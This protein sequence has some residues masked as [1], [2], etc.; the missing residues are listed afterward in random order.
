MKLSPANP[1]FLNMRDAILAALDNKF[2]AQQLT[3]DEHARVQEGIWVAFAKYGMGPNAESNGAQLFG[4]V[5][6]F[7]VSPF[8]VA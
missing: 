4:I 7:S 1:S 2:L 6:D 3:A 5:A 8:A